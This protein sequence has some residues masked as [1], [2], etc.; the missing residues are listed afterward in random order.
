[1]IVNLIDGTYELFRH[2]YGLRRF[3][4]IKGSASRGVDRPYGA[5]GEN[6]ETMTTNMVS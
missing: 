5:A 4:R 6:D 1:M 3:T 2:F